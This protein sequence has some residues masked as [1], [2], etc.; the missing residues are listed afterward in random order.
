MVKILMIEITHVVV[1]VMEDIMFMREL[2]IAIVAAIAVL[3]M[4]ILAVIAVVAVIIGAILIKCV[5]LVAIRGMLKRVRLAAVGVLVE[6]MRLA[7]AGGLIHRMRLPPTVGVLHKLVRRLALVRVEFMGWLVATTALAEIMFRCTAVGRL[8]N[9]RVRWRLGGMR[10][11]GVILLIMLVMLVIG[12][13]AC[14]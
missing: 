2:V 11:R 3:T 10:R 1:A 13:R 8:V 4:V 5:G 6:W 12:Q 14:A 7:T 9:K